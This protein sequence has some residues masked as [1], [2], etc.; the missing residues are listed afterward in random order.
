MPSR[1]IRLMFSATALAPIF[2]TYA[3]LFVFDGDPIVAFTL[4]R[5]YA[6]ACLVAV[7]A[8]GYVCHRILQFYATKVSSGPLSITSLRV[9]DK[10]AITFVVVY[11]LPLV[12]IGNVRIQWEAVV[13]VFVLL[14][15]LIYHSDAYLVNP[16][17]ALPP[18][19]YHF[20]EITANREVTY[21]LVSRRDILNTTDTLEVKQISRFMFLD[22]E[23]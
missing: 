19:R 15:V 13:I 7:A 1:L 21:I 18:F 22:A 12:T 17:L 5:V 6:V 10:S 23:G 4:N 11:L 16:L 9:A 20:Y 14:L 8:L 2:V 3:A